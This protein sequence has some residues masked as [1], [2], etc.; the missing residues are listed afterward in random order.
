MPVNNFTEL[1]LHGLTLVIDVDDTY[2]LGYVGLR[3]PIIIYDILLD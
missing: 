2:S 3:F 1:N